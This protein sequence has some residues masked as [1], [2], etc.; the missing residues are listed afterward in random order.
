VW[1]VEDEIESLKGTGQWQS[2]AEK[3]KSRKREGRKRFKAAWKGLD[4]SEE[5]S[6]LTVDCDFQEVPAELPKKIRARSVDRGFYFTT[7]Q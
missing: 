5:I 2:V 6:C 3:S 7:D 4:T 1:K